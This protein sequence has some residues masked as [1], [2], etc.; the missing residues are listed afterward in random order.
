MDN[1]Q[2]A[3]ILRDTAQ[4]LEIDGAIIGRYRS[5]EKAAE[6][7]D[8]LP[9]SIE[10]LVKEP[11][12]LE[13]LPGIGERMVEHL[14]EIVKTGDYSLRKKL[15]K[16]YPAT[17]LDV[18]QLQSLGP[19]KVAFLWS[20]FKAGTVADVEK[21]AREEKLRDLPGFGEKSEQNILKAA[22]VFKKSSGRFLIDKAEGAAAAIAAHIEKAGKAVASVTPAGS[23]LRGKETVGDLDLLVTLGDGFTSQKHVD[24]LAEH[25]L[26]FPDIDQKLAHGEN[27]VSFTLADGLQVDV[28]LLEKENFGAALLYFTGSKEHNVALRGRANDMGWTLNEYQLATL[29]GEKHVASRTEEEI[30]SKL[31]LEFVPAELRENTGEIAAAEKHKL[32]KLIERR[33]IQGDLQ[34]HTT[35]SDGK[36]SIEEMAEAARKLGHRYIAITD[37]SKAVTVANGL[38][39]K[40]IAEH[41]KGIHAL[42]K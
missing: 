2:I 14:Q 15:L 13:E 38:D 37:H 34:M 7:I 10:Q 19:K 21:L 17:I 30:Y 26:K 27:K 25:I 33:D 35:A 18:L 11:E 40:R 8:S 31:K 1:K 4:L 6:L 5:Y 23:L 12:K 3:R 28:R 41:I 39:E 20:N 24:A 32:P 22:E 42:N 9:E 29:K 16:K 36:N